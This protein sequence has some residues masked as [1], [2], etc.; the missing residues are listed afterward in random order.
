[1]MWR[2]GPSPV[3]TLI[4]L[5]VV[6]AIIAVLISI[7]LPALQQAREQ[8]RSAQCASNLRQLGMA[9]E[10]YRTDHDGFAVPART[11]GSGGIFWY[12]LLAPYVPSDTAFFGWSYVYFCPSKKSAIANPS[13]YGR[14]P[15]G[16]QGGYGINLHTFPISPVSWPRETVVP[17]ETIYFADGALYYNNG[18]YLSGDYTIGGKRQSTLWDGHLT[19][20]NTCFFGGWVTLLSR[21]DAYRYGPNARWWTT[22]W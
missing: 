7:L 5:L 21:F 9:Q 17:P 18:T 8:A 20:A 12:T 4:E 15:T 19:K 6:V 3:F 14:E 2:R 11:S 1:M 16:D 13:V 10:M 22:A